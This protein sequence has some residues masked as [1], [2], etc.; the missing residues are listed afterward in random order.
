M[1]TGPVCWNC[2]FMA[3]TSCR[4]WWV[5]FTTP[6]PGEVATGSAAG[7]Q[8]ALSNA[9]NPKTQR[10]RRNF[11]ETS[12]HLTLMVFERELQRGRPVGRD[13]DLAFLRAQ[14]RVPGFDLV[15]ARR[16]LRDGERAL[17]V[18]H[19][20]VRVV[21]GVAPALHVWVPPALHRENLPALREIDH[22]CSALHVQRR[23]MQDNVDSA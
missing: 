3:S 14:N 19:S 7:P 23:P 10:L 12:I 18:G 6:R 16:E 11:N 1:L 17:Q 4:Y 5:R 9:K 2:F 15:L 20:V 21:N 22:V 8:P 13:G